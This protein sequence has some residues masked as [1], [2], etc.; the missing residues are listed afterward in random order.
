MRQ[1]CRLARGQRENPS[2]RTCLRRNGAATKEWQLRNGDHRTSC[3]WHV[4]VAA[5]RVLVCATR[6]ARRCRLKAYVLWATE[7]QQQVGVCLCVCVCVRVC[8]YQLAGPPNGVGA[9]QSNDALVAE[10]HTVEHVPKVRLDEQT[11]SVRCVRN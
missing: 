10:T 8:S 7:V 4:R 6:H 3:L 2:G 1:R 5:T 11:K 9:G